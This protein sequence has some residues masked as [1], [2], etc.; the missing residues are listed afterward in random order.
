MYICTM[1]SK[2]LVKGTLNVIVLNLLA[3][4]GRMYGYEIFSRVKE[5]TD[6]KILLKDG[7]LYPALQKLTKLGLLT[8][9]EEIVGG[10]KRKYYKLTGEGRVRNHEY[11]AEIKDFFQTMNKILSPNTSNA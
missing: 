7:S 9:E 1:Y 2:E 5:V 4:N 3:E 11:L 6:E 10:R 8:V